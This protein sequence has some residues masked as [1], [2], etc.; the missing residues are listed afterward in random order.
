MIVLRHP[1]GPLDTNAYVL[2]DGT[3]AVV[4]DPAGDAEALLAA[5]QRHGGTVGAVWLTHA[6]FD[7]VA[8]LA[9]LLDLIDVPVY[10]N[11]RDRV[12]FERAAASAALYGI[13]TRQSSA[14]TLPL[15]DAQELSVG[16]ATAR[17]LWTPG[18]APGHMAF[19]LEEAETVLSGDALFRGSIGRTDLPFGDTATLLDAIRRQLFSLPPSTAVLPGHGE[20]TTI[21]DEIRSNPFLR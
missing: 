6:H 17:C 4:V 14:P 1:A 5:A 13:R 3:D 2:V 19:Y 15:V 18:H 21:G 7:H 11:D 16:N 9:D 10:L 8:G 12:L 20:P